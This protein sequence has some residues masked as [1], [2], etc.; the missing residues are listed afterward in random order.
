[1]DGVPALEPGPQPTVDIDG[2]DALDQFVDNAV[3]EHWRDSAKRY[4]PKDPG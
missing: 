1:L 2:I 3:R 4:P